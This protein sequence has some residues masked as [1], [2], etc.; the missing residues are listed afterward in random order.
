MSWPNNKP[1]YWQHEKPI[2]CPK[3]H[4]M[5]WLGGAWWICDECH[6][7]YAQVREG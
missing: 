5:Y 1:K 7:I 4:K 2:K 3:R 6:Q